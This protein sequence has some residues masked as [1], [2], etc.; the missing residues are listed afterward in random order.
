M[1]KHRYQERPVEEVEGM[2][3]VHATRED[4]M[5]TIVGVIKKVLVVN[6]VSEVPVALMKIVKD[7]MLPQAN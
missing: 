4:H 1:R 3:G 2:K 5:H 6:F 7:V